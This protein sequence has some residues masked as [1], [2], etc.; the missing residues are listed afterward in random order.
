M[1]IY[2][3]QQLEACNVN[4]FLIKLDG[5]LNNIPQAMAVGMNLTT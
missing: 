4:A 3:M 1:N 5:A 2:L